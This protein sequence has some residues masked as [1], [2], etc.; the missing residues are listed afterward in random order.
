M[1]KDQCILFPQVN[2][3][4]STLYKDLLKRIP[5]RP[6]TNFIYAAYL[7]PGVAAQITNNGFEVNKQGQHDAKAVMQFFSV[8]SMRLEANKVSSVATSIGAKDALGNFIDFTDEKDALQKAAQ[9]NSTYKGIVSYVVRNGDVF[10]II[11]EAKDSRTQ[12]R[13]HEVA[14]QQAIWGILEQAF[15]GINIDINSFDFNKSLINAVNGKSFLQWLEN[16]KPT[17][18]DLLSIKDIK[19]LFMMDENSSQVQR[20][21]RMF[22][23]MSAAV[24]ETYNALHGAQNYTQYQLSLMNSALDKCKDIQ[25]LD[26][27]ALRQQVDQLEGNM[28]SNS[29]EVNIQATLKNLNNKYK[30]EFNEIHRVGQRIRSLSAAATDAVYALERQLRK[31]KAE[32][33]VTPEVKN[34][35]ILITRIASEIANKKYY[36]GVMGFLSEATNQMQVMEQLFQNANLAPGTNLERSIARAKALMEIKRITDEIVPIVEALSKIEDFLIDESIDPVDRQRIKDQAITVKEFFDNYKNKV[37]D[38]REITMIDLATECL[39]ESDANGMAIADIVAM[40][41]ADSSVWDT[42]YSVGRVSNPLIAAMGSI[43]R[44]A[45][46]ERT[47]KLVDVSLRIRRANERL[48]KS[49]SNSSFMYEPDSN[50]II[51]DIDWVKY[52]EARRQAY[53]NF[54]RQG[55]TGLSLEQDMEQWQEANTEDRVVDYVNNRTERVP[56]KSYRK[57]FPKLTQAQQEYYNEMMEIKGE[58][59]SLL[60]DYAQKQFLPPQ[61][62]RS[63]IDAII[64]SKGNPRKIAKAILNKVKDL[65]IIREDDPLNVK[66]G[67]IDGKEYGIRNGALDNTPERQIPIFFVNELKDQ[68]ELLKDFSGALQAF[69]ATA[70]NYECMNKIKDTVEFMGD[71]ISEQYLAAQDGKKKQTDVIEAKGIRFY[72]DLVSR[73]RNSNTAGII[74]GFIEKHIYGVKQKNITKFTKT[75]QTLLKYT[76]LRS[77]AT[78]VKG[79]ISN[80]LV[81]EL[82]MLIESGAMEF[83]NPLDYTW[84]NAK[85]FGDN[86]INA[87]GRI[88]DFFTNKV[89][90]KAV[91]LAQ[92]FDPLNDIFG[93][94]AQERYFT[95]PLRHLVAKDF[96]FIGYGMGEHFIHYVTM[97]AVLHHQKV[98]IDGKDARLYDAFY[99]DNKVDGSSELKMKSNVTYKNSE[100]NWVPVDEAFLDEVRDRIR[101]CNQNTHGSMNDEDKGLIHQY[102]IGRFVMNLRQW[103]VEHY[104]RRYRGEHWDASL[105]QWREGYYTTVGRLF[106]SWGRAWFHFESEYATRYSELTDAQKANVRRA[107]TEHLVLMSLL[108]LS[109]AL[110]EPEDHKKEFWYRM[111]IYQTKRSLMDVTGS[112][113]L[114]MPMEIDKLVNSPIAATNTVNALLYPFFGLPDIDDKIKSGRYKGWNK[115][116]R[117]LLKYY[118]PFYNHI[119]QLQHMGEDESVFAVFNQPNIK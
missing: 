49:G 33:G 21:K 60:P 67:I 8:N 78:N 29:E 63:F 35:N 39:G 40:G 90:S 16:I 110:G 119:D 14:K 104:S 57:D 81:G 42:L 66:N 72:K 19:T 117:N 100:G 75:A 12:I 36:S 37:A 2:G 77:L 84:A 74:E 97:Y 82:Q 95:G 7:Q 108:C 30:I 26:I 22:R 28:D 99:K 51:S 43:I 93:E 23:G 111:W 73:A 17:R 118:V 11:V 61:K 56:N 46:G 44:D 68:D 107:V 96:S 79:A 3:E 91:L 5:S 59:G 4:E 94:L 48:R 62:R 13:T 87:P 116:G 50:Y 70:I 80:Y 69:A 38:L 25:G 58:L 31:L 113:P 88:M 92:K 105:K 114:G 34:L 109:F 102:M 15:S 76:S 10:N 83:Y 71:F 89:N 20:L 53:R 9:A 32:Q 52:K 115:Y 6:L 112:T 27:A 24:L 85:V 65:F 98:R 106:A 86:T 101:Y 64:K 54:V 18:N 41:E 45:Q 47:K 1:S 103:M 55:S